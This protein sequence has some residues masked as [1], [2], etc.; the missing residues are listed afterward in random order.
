MIDKSRIPKYLVEDDSQYSLKDCEEKIMYW[1]N[2]RK[3]VGIITYKGI[4]YC[5]F[6]VDDNG[7]EYD[8]KTFPVKIK[9]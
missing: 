6:E 4:K 7:G 3:M 5:L 8:Y 1:G 9:H 2:W